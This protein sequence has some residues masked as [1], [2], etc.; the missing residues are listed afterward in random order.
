MLRRFGLCVVI[1]TAAADGLP[2]QTS[3][4]GGARGAGAMVTVA[5]SHLRPG[6]LGEKPTEGYLTQPMVAW[7]GS[8]SGE[9]FFAAAM[10]NFETLTLRRGELNHGVYGEG[11]FDR[12]HPHTWLHEVVLGMQGR[13]GSVRWSL[14]AGKGFVPFGSDDPAVR[15]LVKFPVNHH[16]AQI[17]ERL[18]AGGALRAGRFTIESA[19]FNGDEPEGPNDW[20]NT[21]RLF[22]SW[23]V[24][25]TWTTT[26]EIELSASYAF[27][28]SPEFA[29]GGGLDQRKS[30]ASIR[31][32]GSGKFDYW[33]V[34]AAR[35][36]EFDDSRRAFTFNSLLA[37]ARW[38]LRVL[39]IAARVERTERP[40]EER[41]SS[42]Y[43]SVRPVHDFNILGVTR[44]HVASMN[45]SPT[46]AR[47]PGASPF[48]EV[49][50]AAPRARSRPTALDPVD[51]F[52]ASRLW[53]FTVGWR[54][55]VGT[56]AARPGRYGAAATG[57]SSH[58]H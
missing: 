21:G 35:T 36:A 15:P 8:T 46:S 33:L 44:W 38:S 27:V 43:R 5:L 3:S 12:R 40:E 54:I 26:R 55:Q 7:S 49:S 34:E 48:L 24:R 31:R 57:A 22:D 39:R 30:A 14:H 25:S 58:Q 29:A 13:G 20:P 50:L 9:R 53:S 28:R 18:Q 45:V 17:L 1:S 37:E 52:G 56:M 51:L 42:L 10:L 2:A 47:L 41:T 6:V 23:S 16:H 11:Y 19:A 4:A 32:S